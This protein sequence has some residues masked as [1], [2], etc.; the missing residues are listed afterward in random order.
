M[1]PTRYG[2]VLRRWVGGRGALREGGMTTSRFA[3]RP[4]A[5]WGVIVALALAPTVRRD[6]ALDPVAT[7]R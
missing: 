5:A 1:V 4:L 7:R 2:A 3:V 6:A